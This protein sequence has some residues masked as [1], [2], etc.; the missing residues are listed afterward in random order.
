VVQ[1][2]HFQHENVEVR[3]A[4]LVFKMAFDKLPR[5]KRELV[6]FSLKS[7]TSHQLVKTTWELKRLKITGIFKLSIKSF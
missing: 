1:P 7:V 5:L 2:F 4:S 3:T 6:L